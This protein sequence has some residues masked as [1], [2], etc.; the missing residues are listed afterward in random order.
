M[1]P[2]LPL[3]VRQNVDSLRA[4]LTVYHSKNV[5]DGTVRAT[6]LRYPTDSALSVPP[7]YIPPFI[8]SAGSRGVDLSK[9]C[10]LWTVRKQV[11]G[12]EPSTL[13]FDIG[14]LE[15]GMHELVVNGL[16]DS[17]GREDGGQIL[18]QRR[19]LCIVNRDFPRLTTLG[20]LIEVLPYLARQSEYRD[21]AAAPA[22]PMRLF[23]KFWLELGGNPENAR[24]LM[25]NF[26]GR[27][28][29]ANL[30]FSTHK[31]GCKTDRGM[32]YIV[33]GPPSLI[34]RQ[35]S[36][37]AWSYSSGSRFVFERVRTPWA[38]LP[39]ENYILLRDPE[40]E[41]AWTTEV[42]RWRRGRVF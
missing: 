21:F 37:E 12:D 22:D 33:F 23:D 40:Y 41:R 16:Q 36:S 8:L 25:R 38:S 35:L 4:L 6:L 10:T 11:S 29:E 3:H 2:F 18:E 24:N 1:M 31:E 20:Q 39:F 14:H 27:A 17:C 5:R 19:Y 34:E 32:I 15:K 9:P 7:Y 26:Y 30:L 13:S 42:D 28:E